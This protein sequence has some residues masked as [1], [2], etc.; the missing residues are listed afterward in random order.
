MSKKIVVGFIGAMLI[1]GVSFTTVSAQVA[2]AMTFS[3]FIELLISVG[4]ISADKAAA[5]RSI[6]SPTV[7]QTVTTAPSNV[8]TTS[9]L[10]YNPYHSSDTNR[11]WKISE[12][13][14]ASTT[15]LYNYRVY[16]PSEGGYNRT[17]EYSV[18]TGTVDSYQVGPGLHSTV[19]HSADTNKD[20]RID[21]TELLRVISIKN[22]VG[23]YKTQTG[24]V[25]GFAPITSASLPAVD[26]KING[27]DSVSI[28]NNT[29]VKVTWTSN[30]S[31]SCTA[32]GSAFLLSN[33][34][35]WGNNGILGT[36]G[37]ATLTVATAYAPASLSIGI[38]CRVSNGNSVTDSVSVRI[39]AP[40]TTIQAPTTNPTV[41]RRSLAC[42]TKGDL[43]NDGY[44]D[45]SD[46][47]LLGNVVVGNTSS[48]N[49]IADIDGDGSISITDWVAL[50]RYVNGLDSTFKGC[51]A[52]VQTSNR[53]PL[54]CGTKGDLNND[55]Y[56]DRTDY[57]LH[58]NVV[59]G[60]TSSTNA[61]SD[62]DGDGSIT[63]SDSVILY[64]YVYGLVT[65]FAGCTTVVQN[66]VVPPVVVTPAVNLT[67]GISFSSYP[68]TVVAGSSFTVTVYNSGTKPWGNSH[69]LG[70]TTGNGGSNLQF[71][72]LGTTAAGSSKNVSFTA[73]ITPG[74]YALRAVE[75]NVAWFGDTKTFT[76]VSAQ[77]QPVQ[78]P[79]TASLSVG[80]TCVVPG[81]DVVATVIVSGDGITSKNLEKDTN[82]DGVFGTAA[83][84]G[85]GAGTHTFTTSEGAAYSGRIDLRLVVNGVL[86]DSKS[87]TVSQACGPQTNASQSCAG[88]E[89]SGTGVSKG[90]G[91]YT[92]GYG[93][94][95]WTFTT[96][97][98]PSACQ[99]TCTSGY[100]VSGNSCQ[101][102]AQAAPAISYQLCA[103]TEPSGSY[104]T[105]GNERYQTGYG[106]T[107]WTF[108]TGTPSACQYTCANGAT[109]NGATCA[110]PTPT[111]SLTADTSCAA[112]GSIITVTS[113]VT[114]TPI[115]SNLIQRDTPAENS[116]Y[117]D[118]VFGGNAEYGAVGGSH[119][120]AQA[121]ERDG[122]YDFK[123][124]VNGSLIS[125]VR[126]AA[127]SACGQSSAA[128][129]Q[130]NLGAALVGFDSIIKLLELLK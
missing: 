96:A 59:V 8:I 116:L 71:M 33:G 40:A 65:T 41:S 47:D 3:Q 28:P 27:L 19:F 94:T 89:P 111:V 127:G 75:Q 22:A 50:G 123:A 52:V 110:L 44:I 54:A 31:E 88:T 84:W 18:A 92:V 43:N 99:W 51:T 77:T 67:N 29:V 16:L 125:S 74:T 60:N 69:D 34:S 49:A 9:T 102:I 80:S 57:E 7:T 55:R 100:S 68:T 38:Q 39:T 45:K 98:S 103:G 90:Y 81:T 93:T 2:G 122:Y 24:T 56:I 23:G 17:G 118:G 115:T 63:S 66:P 129:S 26:L 30:G 87:V 76:V 70:L 105:K 35:Q 128:S 64:R 13:E 53:R 6:A 21:G 109:W 36:Y 104:I 5:A 101:P 11:D 114:G 20:W 79:I 130:S 113:Y 117:G 86:K 120:Y 4:V 82:A 12:S 42:G 124:I 73:P 37:E 10:T 95:Q 83:T 72:N 106:T 85:S 14:L 25:D 112:I 32:N 15:A 91:T 78:Q 119:T 107:Q 108:T 48:T 97:G 46:Y 121:V 62:I 126:V 58:T 1:F 61:I